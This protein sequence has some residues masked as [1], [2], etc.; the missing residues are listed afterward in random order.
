M[1]KY[2]TVYYTFSSRLKSLMF[3]CVYYLW[4]LR[5]FFTYGKKRGSHSKLNCGK[6]NQWKY[7]SNH[8]IYNPRSHCF[9]HSSVQILFLPYF[10]TSIAN[11]LLLFVHYYSICNLLTLFGTFQYREQTFP[12]LNKDPLLLSIL[13]VVLCDQNIESDWQFLRIH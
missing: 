1:S 8:K 13:N 6:L 3:I 11:Q 4:M 7:G 5:A 10:G 2:I 9:I 12:R